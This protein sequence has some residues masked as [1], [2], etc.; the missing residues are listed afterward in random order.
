M[1]PVYHT[2]GLA[3][4]NRAAEHAC[5]PG[6]DRGGEAPPESHHVGHLVA[7]IWGSFFLSSS[8]C[9]LISWLFTD[10]EAQ[11]S[12]AKLLEDDGAG[13]YDLN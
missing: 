2:L 12:T 6:P 11:G 4:V 10:E 7:S 1:P 9:L 13:I 8:F 5:D 3:T